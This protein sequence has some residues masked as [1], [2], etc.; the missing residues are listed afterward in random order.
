MTLDYKGKKTTEIKR[1]EIFQKNSRMQTFW[2]H[3]EWR[4][5]GRVESRTSWLETKKIQIQFAAA[6]NKN[7]TVP[8]AARSKA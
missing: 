5:F 4:N 1:D 7:E 8:V 3:K 2:S 6:C